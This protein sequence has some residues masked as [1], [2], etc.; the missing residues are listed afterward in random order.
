MSVSGT[1]ISPDG[2]YWEIDHGWDVFGADGDK[3]GDVADVQN[4]YIT[5][6][7]GFIFKTDM[8]IPVSA[9]SNVQDERVYLN[10]TRSDIER[11]GW[12]R[13]PDSNETNLDRG[14]RRGMPTETAM[15]SG[16]TGY[17]RTLTQRD[18]TLVDRDTLSVPVSE[19]RL[20]VNTRETE[21]G[22]VRVR[23]HVTEQEQ[24]V[25]V[26]L[27]EEEVHVTR[28][29]AQGDYV[30]GNAPANAFEEV[31]IQIPIRG[32]EADVTKQTVVR[33]NVEVHKHV[34]ERQ[35]PV[36]GKVRRE[37]VT[38]EGADGAVVDDTA[39]QAGGMRDRSMIDDL[40]DRSGGA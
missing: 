31:D 36:S 11:Q 40:T 34:A 38:V 22:A 21:R 10:T 20:N 15:S 30:A 16:T 33:E 23:K 28:H 24:T 14:V 7:K 37:D 1:G 25:N 6:S 9:I 29:A 39:S 27:R 12:D 32:E 17:D 3:V 8:Y 35:Q 26:P 2:G 4:D 13:V 19:E 18:D 5:V